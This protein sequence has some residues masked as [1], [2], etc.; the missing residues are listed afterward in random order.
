M[1]LTAKS[2]LG[3]FHV[4]VG[5]PGVKLV[6]VMKLTTI[7]ILAACLQT[8][9]N[10][11]AQNTITFSGKDVNLESVFTAIKKQTSYRF[12]FNTSIIQNASKI[13]IEVKNA[14][15]EQVMNLALKD[16]SL[17]FAIKG[18]TIFVMKKPVEDKSSQAAPPSGDPVTVR[19]RVTDEQGNPLV[20]ATVKVKGADKGVTTDNEGQFTL[21]N[22]DGDGML[23]IS[24]VGRE[25]QLLAVK[26][27]GFLT[28]ALGQKIGSLDET[29]VIAYGTTTKR[30]ATGNVASVKASDIEKQPVNNP[31][32]ALQGRVPGLVI[33]QNTG[34]PGG[35]VTVRIQGQ[36]SINNGNDPLYVIDGVPFASQL[37]T[38]GNHDAVL[39][40]SGGTGSSGQG[41]PLNYINPMDIESIDILKDA[42]A[43]S[44][45]GSR[46]ANGAILITTKRGRAGKAKLDVN[47]LQGSG[48]V[49]RM[50]K[51]MNRRQYLDMR[52]EAYKNDNKDLSTLTPGSR[53]YDLTVWDT[54]RSTDWQK[55]LIGGIAHYTNVNASLSGGVPTLQYRV[56]G[57][58]HRETT[59]FP[60]NFS[61]QNASMHF[62]LNSVS[63]NQ[64]VSLQ[65]SGSY[66]A[67]D[68]R[69][70][71]VDLT[72]DA[73]FLEPV[74]PPLY[75]PDG[76]VNWA[77]APNGT[78]TWQTHPLTNII[79][80]K[81]NNK[82]NN[83]VSSLQINYNLFKGF[84]VK[85]NFG[86]TN[87]Y[88]TDFI[89]LPMTAIKPADRPFSSR[90]AIYGNRLMRSWI[91][92]P[93]IVYNKLI[94]KGNLEVLI[95]S[96]IQQSKSN[97]GSIK[98]EGYSSDQ[99]LESIT[100][101][102]LVTA[103]SSTIS[104]YKYNAIFGRINYNLGSKYIINISARRDGSSRFGANNRFHNFG[105]A[106]AA[107]LFTNEKFLHGIKD[108]L[109]FG[110]VRGS[111]GT[112]GN[113]QIGDYQ[114]LNLY[115][116]INNG[117]P[118]QGTSG[119]LPAGLSNPYLQ[120]EETKK[121]QVGVDLGFIQ[122]RVLLTAN[123]ARNR[124]S[125]QL[126][127]YVLPT[128][129]GN[130]GITNNFPA[131]VQN[132]SWE[133][134]INTI[135]V[136]NKK[137]GWSS[138]INLTIP[139]NKLV[140][141]PDL[142]NSSYI[143][144]LIIGQPLFPIMA[145]TFAGVDPSSGLYRVYDKGGKP[146]STPDYIADK[147]AILN[148]LPIYYG[149]LQNK[150]S[151]RGVELDFI[152]QFVKQKGIN[153][154]INNG[155]SVAPGVFVRGSSNQ[156]VTVLD[157]WQKAGDNKPIQKYSALLV[158]DAS[159]QLAIAQG[160]NVLISDASYIRLKNISLSWR[161]PTSWTGK[162]HLQYCRLFAQGQ[163]ILTITN[164]KGG[165]PENQ[166]FSSLPPLKIF[167]VGINVGL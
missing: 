119:L 1:K 142:E 24:Y 56:G 116:P 50:L 109:S 15:I 43:T 85:T 10:G 6:R 37:Q 143:N 114:F 162:A 136:K 26:G 42:D 149:G 163:N 75:N 34:V 106:G 52:Y 60:G 154:M 12:F 2:A 3:H 28:V 147:T 79:F 124:S 94:G 77:L 9:A 30:F 102:T 133:F 115:Y 46:A 48:K 35:G 123:F 98:G 137:I 45:Y 36:N 14:P 81:Y 167:T 158:G 144:Q 153:N 74:A 78:S 132:M 73:N 16:Q 76:S 122:D 159:D 130:N 8:S 138:N 18:R 99:V 104:A 71:G 155:T 161:I 33:T 103:R 67:S 165:D 83:L 164:Y 105:S 19:G 82:T 38:V 32:L 107:W 93:H 151:Y 23:E 57:T 127:F 5:S 64:K 20:G 117:T 84:Q 126:I 92:E 111:Y 47:L 13:T 72:Q 62:N 80:R 49:T 29:V 118:Y 113:D 40:S 131:T 27:K 96:S 120:W 70:P 22:V 21:T 166:S 121:L 145:Y 89:S 51:V 25:A 11:L 65:F 31:L 148:T 101:A 68:N 100:A 53:T 112:S 69:L 95:G 160:S 129:T 58:Y 39:G 97:S 44:I 156:P 91:I 7:I 134:S 41:N 88:S 87:L 146:T 139:R 63:V 110:K 66:L 157:R 61:N 128:V 152:F 150:V 55:E 135:N 86:Y 4:W 125:N 59:V 140:S 141:F 17:T 54:T 108:L 90:E